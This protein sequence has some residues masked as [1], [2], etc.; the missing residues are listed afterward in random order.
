MPDVKIHLSKTQLPFR[1]KEYWPTVDLTAPT[2][3]E[4]C[5]TRAQSSIRRDQAHHTFKRS[6]SI[7]QLSIVSTRQAVT[8]HWTTT[9]TTDLR[10]GRSLLFHASTAVWRYDTSTFTT[11]PQHRKQSHV[12]FE[13]KRCTCQPR[14]DQP[15]LLASKRESFAPNGPVAFIAR[16]MG[17]VSCRMYRVKYAN[18][19]V[20]RLQPA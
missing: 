12:Q 9:A 13:L 5:I 1:M 10:Y 20:L 11:A 3:P 17:N 7:S 14:A 16:P 15:L 19:I 8:L 2:I 4:G 18:L 6:H